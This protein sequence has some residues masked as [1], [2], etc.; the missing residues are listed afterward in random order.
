MKRIW[1][2]VALGIFAY[3]LF[4][5]VTLPASVVV[6]R[7]QP[8]GVTIAGLDGT[9]W[10]GSAQV[11][12]VGGT[13]LGSIDW[14][15]HVLPLFTMRA[16]ADVNLKR[17][18]GFAKG[19][20]SVGGQQVD[21]KDLTASIPIAAL[22]PQ[23][24]PGGWTGSVNA[25]LA[26]L[27][28]RDGWPVSANGTVDLVNLVGPARRPANLGSFQLKFPTETQEANTLAGTVNDV[29][30]PI[31]IAGRIELKSTDRSYLLDGLVATKPDAPA[32][33]TRTLE[34]LGPPDA[35]GRRQFSLSGTM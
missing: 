26:E 19:A 27:T 11:L 14:S 28:L 9:I 24:A 34:F 15:L 21:L 35:Q 32:D 1:P 6:P 3:L 25:R 18:D 10:R 22:P 29:E 33:F 16:S 31:Q 7:V 8:E 5:V 23:V 12:Q 4:A 17:T 13:H 20:V 2:L 30:G